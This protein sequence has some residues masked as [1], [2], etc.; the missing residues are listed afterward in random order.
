MYKSVHLTELEVIY[1]LKTFNIGSSDNLNIVHNFK[2]QHDVKLLK[3]N[4]QRKTIDNRQVIFI[5]TTNT[6]KQFYNKV[7]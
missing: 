6:F 3:N 7:L 4:S 1:L 2:D 5:M